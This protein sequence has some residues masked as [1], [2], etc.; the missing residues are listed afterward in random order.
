MLRK[1]VLAVGVLALSGCV[2][3]QAPGYQPSIA[4]TQ[5]L[6]KDVQG[7]I[8]IDRID[9]AAGVENKSLSIR[10]STMSGGSDGTYS[11]YLHDALK[12]TLESAGRFDAASATRLSGTLD[13]NDLNGANM[14][15]GSATIGAHFVL[16]R[17]HTT[18][19][20]KEVKANQQWPSSFIG[21]I[22]I[23]AAVQNYATTMQKLVE[24]LFSDPDFIKAA[25]GG[26]AA[27]R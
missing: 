10:G 18:V 27:G 3:L 23:P 8:G 9:A 16:S 19:F 13:A 4:A 20:D 14:S 6:M 7:S 17:E 22:A 26:A 25:N 1:I 21:A 2:S 5:G 15:T 24:Q 11:T 12:S